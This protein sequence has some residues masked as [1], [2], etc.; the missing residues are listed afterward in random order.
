LG[1]I[2]KPGTSD[3][4]YTIAFP[5]FLQWLGSSSVF[6]SALIENSISESVSQ[7]PQHH[8]TGFWKCRDK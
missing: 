6:T 2:K 5:A 4:S 8:L 7:E 3:S 1:I